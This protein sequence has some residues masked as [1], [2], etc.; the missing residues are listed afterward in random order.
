MY[1]FLVVMFFHG[2]SKLKLGGH[3]FGDTI[4]IGGLTF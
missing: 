4:L 3:S 1:C 2:Y